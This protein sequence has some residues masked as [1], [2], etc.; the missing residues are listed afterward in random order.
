MQISYLIFL[1]GFQKNPQSIQ[2]FTVIHEC[3]MPCYRSLNVM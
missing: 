1:D 2:Y 3:L